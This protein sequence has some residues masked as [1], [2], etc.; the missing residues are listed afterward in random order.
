MLKLLARYSGLTKIRRLGKTRTTKFACRNGAKKPQPVI[1][2]II[3]AF[4]AQTVVIKGHSE[5][6]LGVK[7]YAT[8]CL[9]KL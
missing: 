3:E 9:T 2:A 1:D 8:D 6:E 7:M 5:A 4:T